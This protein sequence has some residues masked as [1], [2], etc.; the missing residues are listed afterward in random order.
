[1]IDVNL[2][3]GCE[4]CTFADY[5]GR[6]CQYGLLFPVLVLMSGKDCPNKNP[7]TEKQLQEQLTYMEQKT[8]NNEN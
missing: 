4:S 6:G 3:I 1:M 5:I 7:K 2:T 8:K